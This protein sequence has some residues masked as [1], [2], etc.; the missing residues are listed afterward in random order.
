GKYSI[1][2]PDT[3]IVLNNP[4][5]PKPDVGGDVIPVGLAPMN[6]SLNETDLVMRDPQGQLWVYDIQNDKL[7]TAPTAPFVSSKQTGDLKDSTQ[8]FG[9]DLTSVTSTAASQLGQAMA[10]FGG[11]SGTAAGLNAA[12]LGARTCPP[13]SFLTT[14]QPS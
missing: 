8:A 7:A 3:N 10:S 14:P 2:S 11:D 12:P 13:E 5:A 4:K 9:P 6:G 1:S